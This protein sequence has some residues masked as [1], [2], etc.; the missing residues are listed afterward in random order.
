MKVQHLCA[1]IA[2]VTI[3]SCGSETTP[4]ASCDYASGNLLEDTGFRTLAAPRRERKWSASGH[5]NSEAFSYSAND[6]TLE[7]T[8]VGSE[9]WFLLSQ[10]PDMAA[11][12]GKT[13]EYTAELK[14]DLTESTH[15][16]KFKLGGGLALLGKKY[17]KN[18]LRAHFPHEPHMGTHDWF[19]ARVVAEI[20]PRTDFLRVSIMHQAGGSLQARNPSL[21]IVETG[22]PLTV[23]PQ[24]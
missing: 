22:C 14:L 24:T 21:R 4:S 11:L 7:I 2:T 5:A 19:T 13:I 3:A 9:P 12:A 1:A 16:H 23:L 10:S 17:N 15:P 6:G 18:V 8:Q 20:P